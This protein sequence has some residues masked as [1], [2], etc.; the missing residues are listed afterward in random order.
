MAPEGDPRWPRGPLTDASLPPDLKYWLWQVEGS[1]VRAGQRAPASLLLSHLM[2]VPQGPASAPCA[3]L[4][5]PDR[6]STRL[7]SSH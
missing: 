2:E 7:N 1:A 4:G 3:S 5:T 6:K